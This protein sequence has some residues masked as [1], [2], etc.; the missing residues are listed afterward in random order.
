[1]DD[2]TSET[3]VYASLRFDG[4][5]RGNPGNA[6]CGYALVVNPNT[7]KQE[8]I[9]GAF[10]LGNQRTNNYAEYIGLI[11]GLKHAITLGVTDIFVEG[12]SM[13]VIKQSAGLWK[14][15]SPSLL[16]LHLKVIGLLSQFEKHTFGHILRAQNKEADEL[17][18]M[19]MDFP[20]VYPWDGIN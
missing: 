15:N 10:Y 13:L 5:S 6:G 17:A 20:H 4:G 16:P 7:D 18:N 2:T 8:T 1:M 9:Q 14:V 12:D 19:A 11:E 3:S